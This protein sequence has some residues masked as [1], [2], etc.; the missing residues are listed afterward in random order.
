[1]RKSTCIIDYCVVEPEVKLGCA[2]VCWGW[3]AGALGVALGGPALRPRASPH[4][5][6]SISASTSTSPCCVGYQK[7]IHYRS[8]TI[9]DGR[10][11]QYL[12]VKKSEWG[13]G[14]SHTSAFFKIKISW[15]CFLIH[16]LELTPCSNNIVEKYF[17]VNPIS[18]SAL[19]LFSP[20]LN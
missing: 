5:P 19:L 16:S 1:M 20:L 9:N 13:T 7:R 4:G 6:R 8:P 2:G 12:Y 14:G 15:A 17:L 11:P 3:G 18:D 10:K